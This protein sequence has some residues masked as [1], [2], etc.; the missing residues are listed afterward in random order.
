MTALVHVLI[1]DE[2]GHVR[3]FKI[4]RAIAAARRA[5]PHWQP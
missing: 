2:H 3:L 5:A 1:L 4:V